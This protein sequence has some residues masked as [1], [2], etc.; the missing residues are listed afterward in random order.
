MPAAICTLPA[1]G[2]LW[3]TAADIVRLGTG[4][5]SLLPA[6]LAREALTPQAGPAP[7]T[8]IKVGL[9]WLLRPPEEVAVHAGASLV[10]GTVLLTRGPQVVVAMANR[11][12]ALEPVADLVLNAATH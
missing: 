6:G 4:W 11:L 8:A 7:G 9:G 1:I 10:A 2:G 3:L 12:A 5:A